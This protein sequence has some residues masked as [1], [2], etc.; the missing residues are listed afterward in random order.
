MC[1]HTWESEPSLRTA[2]PYQIG[3][4]KQKID[5]DWLITYNTMR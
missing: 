5:P 4:K 3:E 1:I 2:S